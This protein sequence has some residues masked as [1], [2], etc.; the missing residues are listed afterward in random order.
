MSGEYGD[1]GFGFSFTESWHE[2]YYGQDTY[3]AGAGG[4]YAVYWKN[5]DGDPEDEGIQGFVEVSF[6]YQIVLD[7]WPYTGLSWSAE[8]ETTA[9]YI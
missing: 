2:G 3:S 1:V 4:E 9:Y 5:D 7:G 6:P 8:V